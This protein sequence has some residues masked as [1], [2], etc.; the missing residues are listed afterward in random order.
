MML[1]M[2]LHLRIKIFKFTKQMFPMIFYIQGMT[3]HS[4]IGD[5]GQY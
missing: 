3:G 4:P 5:G 1:T 2:W